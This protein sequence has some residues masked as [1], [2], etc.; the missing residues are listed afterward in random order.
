MAPGTHR[1][2]AP[3]ISSTHIDEEGLGP[4]S[5]SEPRGVSKTTIVRMTQSLN[6]ATDGTSRMNLVDQASDNAG[7]LEE[8]M[9]LPDEDAPGSPKGTRK[10][11][12]G[13]GLNKLTK[14]M[15]S[16]MRLALV[17]GKK[18]PEQPVQAA[19][20]ASESGIVVWDH[21]P[22]YTHWKHYKNENRG[23]NRDILK[24]HRS[25]LAIRLWIL[26]ITQQKKYVLVSSKMGCVNNVIG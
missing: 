17:E 24:D 10:P 18:R 22:I 4:L 15:G 19:K 6:D 1:I 5:A 20:L 7:Q 25:Y 11:T 12:W 9:L 13:R 14:A 3:P 8:G 21:M 2:R 16:K 23:K 26:M